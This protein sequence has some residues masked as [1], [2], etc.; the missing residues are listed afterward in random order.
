MRLAGLTWNCAE[1]DWAG[2]NPAVP[3]EAEQPSAG[4]MLVLFLHEAAQ[5][6]RVCIRQGA[7]RSRIASRLSH[8]IFCSIEATAIF[9][10]PIV[11]QGA[12]AFP[13]CLSAMD[14]RQGSS[15]FGGSTRGS[16]QLGQSSSRGDHEDPASERVCSFYG[17][18]LTTLPEHPIRIDENTEVEEDVDASETDRSKRRPR[19]N[20]QFTSYGE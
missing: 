9:C 3:G 8:H 2:S 6:P 4:T 1:H 15:L 11:A 7:S 20:A 13:R 14:N 12:A 5:I 16:S 10:L 19:R 17:K 18:P